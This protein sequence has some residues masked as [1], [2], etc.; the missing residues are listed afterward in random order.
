MPTISALQQDER[1]PD[2]YHIHFDDGRAITLGEALVVSELLSPGASL[3]DEAIARLLAAEQERIL[4]DRAARYL[5]NRPRSRTEVRRRLLR[6]APG[7]PAPPVEAV[8]RA[9]ERMERWGYLDDAAFATYWTEQRDRF[10]PRSARA[11]Q[12]ELRQRGVDAE[13]AGVSA[14]P[15]TDEERAVA[16]GRKRLR[17]LASADQR[18]FTLRMG[19]YLQR[20]GFSYGIARAAIRRL[21]DES[22]VGESGPSSPLDLDEMD[23][24]DASDGDTGNEMW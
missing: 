9:L 3:D 4:V 18:D 16:A 5:A 13:T 14:T 20:R 2:R 8:E 12:Q 24:P 17:A 1:R 11:I 15:D 23:A 22:R 6:T 7:K 19:A 21:W 10:S